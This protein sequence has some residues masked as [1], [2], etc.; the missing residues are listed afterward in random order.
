MSQRK[1][2]IFTNPDWTVPTSFQLFMTERLGSFVYSLVI[3]LSIV[4]MFQSTTINVFYKTS[5]F[6]V[7][8]KV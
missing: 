7:Y 3:G 1:L 4:F 5:A 8:V 6:I 2:D